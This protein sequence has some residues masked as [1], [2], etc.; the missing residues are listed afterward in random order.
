MEHR[1]KAGT[2]AFESEKRSTDPDTPTAEADGAHED[3]SDQHSHPITTATLEAPDLELKALPP[4]WEKRQTKAE[5]T[6]FVDHNTRRT[7]WLD[8]RHYRPGF[9]TVGLPNGWEVRET[10]RGVAYF[11]DHNTKT[12]TWEDPRST[13]TQAQ[14][15]SIPK[16]DDLPS[17]MG[18]GE[19]QNGGT[20]S[21]GPKSPIR[22][23]ASSPLR[24]KL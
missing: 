24:A 8:P 18:D 10:E 22:P 2:G 12:N 17:G 9:L 6:Y 20:T 5:A 14:E 4:G 21:E 11:V 3:L 15:D 16:P 7:T 13:N 1:E 19:T 23:V